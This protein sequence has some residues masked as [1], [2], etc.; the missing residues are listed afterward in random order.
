ME[1]YKKECSHA[2]CSNLVK[3]FAIPRPLVM[4][5]LLLAKFIKMPFEITFEFDATPPFS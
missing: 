4:V 2:H 1:L 5:S 3:H